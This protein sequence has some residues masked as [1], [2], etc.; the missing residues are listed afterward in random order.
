MQLLCLILNYYTLYKIEFFVLFV[1]SFMS[2]RVYIVD[3]DRLDSFYESLEA[4]IFENRKK[5]ILSE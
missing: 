1:L 4:V 3:I 2:A 5:I